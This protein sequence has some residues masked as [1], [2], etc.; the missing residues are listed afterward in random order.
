MKNVTLGRTGITVPQN[1]FGAL[2]VQRVSVQEAAALLRRAFEGGMRFFDTAR[3][4][5]DSEEKL[6]EAF[7]GMRDRLYIATKTA[8]TT[9]EDFWR[10]LQTSLTNL[11]TEYVD[12]YQFHCVNRCYAP[13]D[14]TGMYE[15]MLEAQAQGKIRHIGITTHKLGV[16]EEI[17][18]SGLYETL[19][20]PFSYLSSEREE[21]L[22]H[23]CKQANMGFIAM[24]ALAGGL[25]TNAKAAMAYMQQ[26]DNALPIWGVQRPQ[27]LDDWLAMMQETPT[28]TPEIEA[29]LQ[30]E[31]KELVGD[32]C[33][34]CGY[35]MPCPAGIMIN[36]CARMSLML[37]RAPSQ[38]WLT[39][40]M[41]A[42]M[43]KIE[44]CL[45]CGACRKKCPY[46][47]DTPN[48]LKRNYEDY[49][50]VLAGKV[51]V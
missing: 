50:Q 20:Y 13:G 27:E 44:G 10:D 6:G 4:Y 5:S 32:F 35:C 33:R 19:Q 48:L 47:L 9:P 18:A 42:E 49:K 34:G 31:R 29:F 16:A 36:Q 8:A 26:F 43:K 15:C 38:N 40:E 25:I 41:Q 46:S 1:A 28:M 11:R 3:A 17:V 7:Q 21:A 37:R 14:G 12:L 23:A 30:K 24:K 22:V 45:E 51:T 39:P 2:P